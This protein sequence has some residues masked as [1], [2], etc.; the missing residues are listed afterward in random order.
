MVKRI[1]IEITEEE[2]H[3]LNAIAKKDNMSIKKVLQRAFKMGL[4]E[5]ITVYLEEMDDEDEE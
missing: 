3:L 1:D 2:L 4:S 5:E